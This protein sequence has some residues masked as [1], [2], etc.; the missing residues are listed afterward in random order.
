MPKNPPELTAERLKELLSYD[1]ETGV[2][3]HLITRSG[4][5]CGQVAGSRDKKGYVRLHIDGKK[6]FAHRVAWFYV[7]GLWPAHQ[8]DHR[9]GINDANWI[10]NLRDATNAQNQQNSKLRRDNKARRI[11]VSWDSRRQKWRAQ[12]RL[13]KKDYWLGYF[14][15]EESASQAYAE[16][17]QKLHSFQP[18]IRAA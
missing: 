14:Q 10:D 3:R 8:V 15:S 4:V 9:N 17:K 12:I 11:G 7:H 18:T 16:A 2:F 13:R 5:R 6:Y 1:P